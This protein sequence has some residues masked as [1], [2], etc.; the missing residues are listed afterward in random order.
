MKKNPTYQDLEKENKIFRR[1]LLD[2]EDNEKIKNFFENNRAVMLQ[3]HTVTK[4]ITDANKAAIKFYGYPKTELLQ[5]TINEVHTLPPDKISK[6]MKEAVK[7]HSNFFEF[8]HKVANGEIKDVEVYA[9]PFRNASEV[10]MIL[11]IHD[12]TNRKITEQTLKENESNLNALI[13]NQEESIWSVDKNYNYLTFNKFFEK[14]Y[15]KAYNLELQKG[16]NAI[17]ILTTELQD[18]WKPKYDTVLT[19][20]KLNFEFNYNNESGIKYFD[21]KLNPIISDNQIIGIAAISNDIT[22]RK[23]AE[24]LQILE[25]I[26]FQS[27]IDAV[28]A[29]I[30]VSDIKTNELLYLNKLGRKSTGNKT[31]M[32]CFA[33]LQKGRTEPCEFCTNHLLLDKNGNPNEPYVWE[34]QNTVTNRWYQC[35]DKAIQWPDGRLVRLEIATDITERK[36]AEKTV[37]ESEQKLKIANATKD[38][39]FSII[40]HDLRSPFN[41]ILDFS[42]LLLDNHAKLDAQERE[43]LINPILNSGKETLKL[44]DNLLNWAKTQ[45]GQIVFNPD[46]YSLEKIFINNI[47]QNKNSANDK[48][49]QLSYLLSGKITVYADSYMLHTILRNLISNAIKFTHKNGEIKLR[50]EQDEN[51]V[52][53]S[54]SDS[55][56]GISKEKHLK[57][58]DISEKISTKGTENEKGSGLGL[59]LCKEFIEKHDGK[60]WV[61]SKEKIGSTFLFSL[62]LRTK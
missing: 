28:D 46:F 17:D 32:K 2:S 16:Q 34:F 9:S 62:P 31:G 57:I 48:N 45:T 13:N 18:F 54:V 20:Q 4:R 1:R 47:T 5:K 56:I 61:E 40:A 43:K 6:L 50:A 24:E 22:A 21:V 7:N 37:K 33:A 35:R 30:Y 39:F 52:I 10:Y 53:I 15:F 58:F 55:G 42:G 8:R 41:T 26:K 12:I 38:K 29:V 25:N 36:L 19:G 44:L 49:I 3:V 11:T 23:N 27:T 14:A 59:V 60:I 51:N